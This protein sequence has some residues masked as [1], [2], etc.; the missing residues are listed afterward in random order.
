[1]NKK[2]VIRRVLLLA[3]IVLFIPVSKNTTYA[4][5]QNPGVHTIYWEATLSVDI[6]KKK[7]NPATPE[8]TTK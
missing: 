2:N 7:K 5:T 6:V 1:M 4:E 8:E 3:L